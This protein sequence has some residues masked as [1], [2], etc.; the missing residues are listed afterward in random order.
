M[1]LELFAG[2][3]PIHPRAVKP[4]SSTRFKACSRTV[5]HCLHGK[6]VD[7]P[8]ANIL[9]ATLIQSGREPQD[10][11]SERIRIRGRDHLAGLPYDAS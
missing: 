2:R 5:D 4:G 9:F 10:S 1:G 7:G 11:F 6:K 3:G 8:I